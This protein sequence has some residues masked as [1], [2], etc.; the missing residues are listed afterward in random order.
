M[1]QMVPPK[2][3][4]AAVSE[5]LAQ[6]GL[7]MAADYLQIGKQAVLRL[8]NG[9]HVRTGTVRSIQLRLSELAN[10]DK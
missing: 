2:D 5:I 9:C 7:S 4:Q 8:A 10:V 1:D 6:R 3:L